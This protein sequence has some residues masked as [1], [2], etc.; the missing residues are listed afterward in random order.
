[1]AE[2]AEVMLNG[3]GIVVLRGA[4]EDPRRSTP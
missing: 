2:W 3:P 4:F 1:M